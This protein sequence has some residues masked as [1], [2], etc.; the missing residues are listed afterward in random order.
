[1]DD[2]AKI[3]SQYRIEKAEEDLEVARLNFHYDKLL[4]SVNRSYYSIFHAVRA[5]LAFDL[6]DSKRHSAIIA[7]FNKH[8]IASEKIDKKYYKMLASAFDLRIKSDY[9]DFY[10][11]SKTEAKE[12]LDNAVEFINMVKSFIENNIK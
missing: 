8:Y 6:F 4:Q 10:V 3:L 12:Q 11:I 1:M 5:L 7:Y 2:K 9:Q